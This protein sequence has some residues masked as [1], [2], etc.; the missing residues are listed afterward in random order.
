MDILK[1]IKWHKNKEVAK[2]SKL[3]KGNDEPTFPSVDTESLENKKAKFMAANKK[4]GSISAE[5]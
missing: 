5:K 2:S 3:G 4:V 1:T